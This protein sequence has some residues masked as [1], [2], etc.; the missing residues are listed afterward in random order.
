[1]RCIYTPSGTPKRPGVARARRGPE[2]IHT[3][4]V[5]RCGATPNRVG[6]DTLHTIPPP[7]TVARLFL[8]SC[9][10]RH[11][12]V[13]RDLHGSRVVVVHSI[14]RYTF[15]NPY[16][17]LQFIQVTERSPDRAAQ[18]PRCISVFFGVSWE[19]RARSSLRWR[20]PVIRRLMPA[21]LAFVLSGQ[22]LRKIVSRVIESADFVSCGAAA[23][24]SP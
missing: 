23:C 2:R 4:G 11:R 12:Q 20:G 14:T 13:A 24:L 18:E 19:L 17:D 8:C 16:C 1:M 9:L 3:T 21:C 15:E 10:V 22:S 6:L 5:S 7:S